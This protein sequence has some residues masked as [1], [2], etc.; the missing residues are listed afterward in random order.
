M[1]SRLDFAGDDLIVLNMNIIGIQMVIQYKVGQALH[2]VD[3]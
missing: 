2:K 3:S 1:A